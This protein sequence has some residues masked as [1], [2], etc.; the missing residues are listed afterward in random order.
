MANDK[1]VTHDDFVAVAS[2]ILRLARDAMVDAAALRALLEQ[3][4]LFSQTE[5]D[6]MK[7][8]AQSQWN[9][10]L[11]AAADDAQVAATDVAL[12][13]LLEEFQGPSQ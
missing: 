13:K 11:K 6:Q 1:P 12:R 9:G 4:G 5:F 2:F 10:D 7:A 8:Y 3:R